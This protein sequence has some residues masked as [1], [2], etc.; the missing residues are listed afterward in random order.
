[1]SLCLK[2]VLFLFLFFFLILYACSIEIKFTLNSES[3]IDVSFLFKNTFCKIRNTNQRNVIVMFNSWSNF[4][5]VWMMLVWGKNPSLYESTSC[6]QK[7]DG[8]NKKKN[9]IVIPIVALVAGILMLLVIAAAAVI[10]GL[11]QRK[12]EGKT[13][14]NCPLHSFEFGYWHTFWFHCNL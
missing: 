9:K 14:A 7:T 12:T 6:N 11:K 5:L 2:L 13:A 3:F 10:C 1:M 4:I 8:T